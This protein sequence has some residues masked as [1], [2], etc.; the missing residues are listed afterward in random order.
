MCI[1]ECGRRIEEAAEDSGCATERDVA[2][3]LVRIGGKPEAKEVG[4]D[5]GY[6][7][8]VPE[9]VAQELAKPWIELDGDELSAPTG[10]R[11]CEGSAARSDLDDQV[12]I[13]DVALGYELTS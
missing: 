9:S 12:L 11:L 2:Y 7:S 3:H 4:L 6:V 5:D 10:Q 13:R 1:G 8:I